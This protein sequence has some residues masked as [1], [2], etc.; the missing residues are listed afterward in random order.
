[1]SSL[2]LELQKKCTDSNVSTSDVLRTALAVAAKLGVE[3]VR[4]L[5]ENELGGYAEDQ[6]V[7][8]YRKVRGQVKVWN[9][10]TGWQLVMFDDPAYE[11]RVT[12]R[13]ATRSI[14]E[15]ED[16]SAGSG[17]LQMPFSWDLLKSS[18][19]RTYTPLKPSFHVDQTTVRGIIQAVRDLILDWSL[20]LEKAGVLGEDEAFSQEEKEAAAAIVFIIRDSAE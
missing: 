20:R 18:S 11:R 10:W 15:L 2:V 14:A 17:N 1:M 16:V 6:D 8:G 5:C 13:N 19:W 12:R 7:P 3:E 9:P 4:R